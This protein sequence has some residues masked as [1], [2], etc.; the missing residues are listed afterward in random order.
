MPDRRDRQPAGHGHS[1]DR[2]RCEQ[3]EP[4]V[5]ADGVAVNEVVETDPEHPGHELQE[6][7]PSLCSVTAQICGERLGAA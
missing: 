6:A 2:G 3:C 5:I 7:K 1:R 4:A